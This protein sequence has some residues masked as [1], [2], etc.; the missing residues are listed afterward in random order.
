MWLPKYKKKSQEYDSLRE[1]L[2]IMLGFYGKN[3]FT[4]YPHTY[5][6]DLDPAN[7]IA[8]AL[9]NNNSK[10]LNE[11]L[12]SNISVSKVKKPRKDIVIMALT[13]LHRPVISAA[14]SN[15]STRAMK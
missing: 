10:S 7:N 15:V 9:N 11:Y 5:V 13:F 3:N 4:L 14:P 8:Q 6:N 2:D 1:T 12:L